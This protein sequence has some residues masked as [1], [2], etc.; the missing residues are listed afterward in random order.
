MRLP[1][2]AARL[3][4]LSDELECPELAELAGEIGRRPSGGRAPATSQSMT[5]ALA[6][7]IRQ[8]KAANPD[9]SQA[10]IASMLN[11]NPGRVSEALK[12]KRK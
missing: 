5:P 10:K 11:I 12:G 9:L 8:I 1:Q 3:V 6:K 7:N 4:E 2:V